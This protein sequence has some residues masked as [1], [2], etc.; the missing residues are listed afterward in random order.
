M[1]KRIL[2]ID[3]E[4]SVRKGF[5]LSLED[6]G[7]ETDTAADGLKGVEK[8]KNSQYDMIL[9]DLKMPNMDGVATLREIRKLYED[10]PVYIITAFHAEF[11]DQLQSAT[12]E[13]IEFELLRKP[14]ESDDLCAIVDGV[15]G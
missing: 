14:I 11:F 2:I 13:G 1:S 3:D 5:S 6:A 15:L 8:V 9:L 12:K 7:Y 10:L 4:E